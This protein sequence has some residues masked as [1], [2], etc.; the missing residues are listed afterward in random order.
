MSLDYNLLVVGG[1]GMPKDRALAINCPN[2]NE[3]VNEGGGGRLKLIGRLG[4]RLAIGLVEATRAKNDHRLG[5]SLDRTWTRFKDNRARLIDVQQGGKQ[6]AWRRKIV[7]CIGND[8]RRQQ[9]NR[10]GYRTQIAFGLSENMSDFG[11]NIT[12]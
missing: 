8:G 12:K 10:R 7:R 11:G 3:F 6:I 2:G 4:R 5:S 9:C 1:G